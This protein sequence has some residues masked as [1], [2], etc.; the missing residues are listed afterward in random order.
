MSSYW[1]TNP[2]NDTTLARLGPYLDGIVGT[3]GEYTDLYAAINTGGWKRMILTDSAIL[4]QN[5]TISSSIG[6]IWSLYSE[7][8]RVFN[9]YK[10]TVT[11]NYWKFVGIKLYGGAAGWEL[12]GNEYS[13]VNCS[14]ISGSSHGL[15]LNS[16]SGG[17]KFMGCTFAANGG[18]GIKIASGSLYN[19]F[20]G[21]DSYSNTGYGVNSA[22]SGSGYPIFSGCR[23]GTNT[24]G[25]VNGTITEG[26]YKP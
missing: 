6:F 7:E 5:L 8:G 21:C 22:V 1:Q 4:S 17:F 12:Q 3:E 10:I 15:Y 2:I 23:L 24:A 26:N 19:L 16:S 20:V 9:D 14:T 11:G 25:S 18:D 13:M